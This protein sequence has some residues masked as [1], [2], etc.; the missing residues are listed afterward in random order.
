MKNF[1]YYR[2]TTA[3]QAV[4]LLEAR[5]GNTEMLAGGTDLLSLQKDYI[6]QPARVVSL[7]GI[8]GL[9]TI[10]IGQRSV[11]IG[12]GVTLAAIAGHV[13]LS[14]LFPALASAA[15]E[16]GGPQIRNM[17]TLG[18]NLCQRNRCWYFRDEH[19]PC[20]LRGGNRCSAIEGE[21]KYHAIFTANHR[22]VIA[23]PSTLATG[24]IALGASAE[25]LGPQNRRRTVEL[26]KFYRAPAAANEREHTLAAN[27]L[28]TSV[29]IPVRGLTNAA[30]EVR[31]KQS[32]D[33]PIVQCAVAFSAGRNGE[34]ATGVRIVLSHVAPTPMIA[35]AA[36][37]AV[38]NRAITAVAATAAG[39][40]AAEGAKPL[41]QNGYK[42]RLVEVAVKRALMIAAGLPRYW[43]A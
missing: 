25:I 7:N 2:P 11:T 1:T 23:S 27:E 41:S 20:L 18:G 33:W 17:G 31:Q 22:C 5:F 39:R 35:E 43:E 10:T 24:L 28:I 32:S 4:A 9:N 16:I 26:A 30:Y 29:T 38:E 8:A 6:A 21:N 42:V 19:S 36:G 15:G 12:A 34:K 14:R 3:E 37:R 13:Q 40:A